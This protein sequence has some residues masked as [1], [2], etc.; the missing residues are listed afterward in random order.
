M[1]QSDLK[2]IYIISNVKIQLHFE[3]ISGSNGKV[4]D[5]SMTVHD[6]PGHI[7]SLYPTIS[8]RKLRNVVI[9]PSQVKKDPNTEKSRKVY[10]QFETSYVEK[11]MQGSWPCAMS[12]DVNDYCLEQVVEQDANCFL[13]WGLGMGAGI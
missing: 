4:H 2:K 1:F 8:G 12:E 9:F 3:I 6:R 7:D 5:I 11:L 13:P 10:I